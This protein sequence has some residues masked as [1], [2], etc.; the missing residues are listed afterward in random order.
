MSFILYYP[1][2]ATATT[3]VTLP[4]PERGNT[5]SSAKAQAKGRTRGGQKYVYSTGADVAVVEY[6]FDDLTATEKT[7]LQN[8]F[9]N[10]ADG[11]VNDFEFDDHLGETRAASFDQAELEWTNTAERQ[12]PDADPLWSVALRFELEE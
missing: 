10:Q 3:T 1:D 12:I 8:F 6:D 4:S 2:K 11:M 7:A 9:D 5:L